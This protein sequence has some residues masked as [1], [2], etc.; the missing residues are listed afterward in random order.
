VVE[1]FSFGM[2]RELRI[3][4]VRELELPGAISTL[5]LPITGDD[6]IQGYAS[7]GYDRAGGIADSALY[8][9]DLLSAGD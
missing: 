3:W 9:P 1:S 5:R 4:N 6:A 7:I 8:R 2:D